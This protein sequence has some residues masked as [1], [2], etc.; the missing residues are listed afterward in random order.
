MPSRYLNRRTRRRSVRYASR[1]LDGA[2][3]PPLTNYLA[4]ACRAI[5]EV[6]RI[7]KRLRPFMDEQAEILKESIR[8]KE[9]Q[10]A[11]RKVYGDDPVDFTPP[12]SRCVLTPPPTQAQILKQELS[13]ARSRR[14]VALLRDKLKIR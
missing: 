10:A 7:G 1:M 12:P 3:R 6:F 13:L 8:Q 4:L 14:V 5:E 11:L 2:R 9:I